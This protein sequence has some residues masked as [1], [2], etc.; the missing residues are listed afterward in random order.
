VFKRK[1]DFE[2]VC[3]SAPTGFTVPQPRSRGANERRTTTALVASWLSQLLPVRS[4]CLPP[5][6][7]EEPWKGWWRADAQR[8]VSEPAQP[9]ATCSLGRLPQCGCF[10]AAA[11]A[12]REGIGT[13]AARYTPF[14]R[15]TDP[16]VLASSIV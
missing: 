5:H 13:G 6:G 2:S 7:S 12:S 14:A 8:E 11:T 1:D 10:L 4:L 9:A 15:E 16:G 3:V